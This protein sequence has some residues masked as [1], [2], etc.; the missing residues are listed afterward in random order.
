MLG[1]KT[2]PVKPLSEKTIYF[3]EHT[4]STCKGDKAVAVFGKSEYNGITDVWW[5]SVKK[6]YLPWR[7][8]S[9]ITNRGTFS[10]CV[11]L[12]WWSDQPKH[13]IRLM[14]RLSTGISI[15]EEIPT[16]YLW[17]E[18]MDDPRK[19]PKKVEYPINRKI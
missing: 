2:Y 10:F 3:K 19:S 13:P 12:K 18:M 15:E 9:V 17:K 7:G 5:D 11:H 8:G 4:E 1:T 16:I 14:K 6:D